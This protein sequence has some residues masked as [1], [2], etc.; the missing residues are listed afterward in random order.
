M[1]PLGKAPL[2]NELKEASD[3]SMRLW[4]DGKVEKMAVEVWGLFDKVASDLD[5]SLR[6]IHLLS[7]K[8]GD[9]DLL[10]RV[11]EAVKPTFPSEAEQ[12]I[13]SC[14]RNK[15]FVPLWGLADIG[16]DFSVCQLGLFEGVLLEGGYPLAQK[17]FEGGAC[18]S[19]ANERVIL[20]KYCGFFFNNISNYSEEKALAFIDLAL[21]RGFDP[22]WLDERFL[23][24]VFRQC[25]NPNVWSRL[26][27]MRD[28]NFEEGVEFLSIFCKGSR[29]TDK[30]LTCLEQFLS[31]MPEG[32]NLWEGEEGFLPCYFASRGMVRNR[33]EDWLVDYYPD[34]KRK[35]GVL[36]SLGRYEEAMPLIAK[37]GDSWDTCFFELI[38]DPNRGLSI[39]H[40]LKKS[41]QEYRVCLREWAIY[42]PEKF[43]Q[44]NDEVKWLFVS[45]LP[46]ESLRELVVKEE[47]D[48]VLLQNWKHKDF[49]TIIELS[50]AFKNH[51]WSFRCEKKLRGLN[52]QAVAQGVMNGY[53]DFFV[54]AIGSL[55][56]DQLRVAL[57]GLD[58]EYT[59]DLLCNKLPLNLALEVVKLT[60]EDIKKP[61]VEGL[62]KRNFGVDNAALEHEVFGK[63]ASIPGMRMRLDRKGARKFEECSQDFE[64]QYQKVIEAEGGLQKLETFFKEEGERA[65]GG[66]RDLLD[67][68]LYEVGCSLKKCR[69]WERMRV[70]VDRMEKNFTRLKGEVSKRIGML[71]S[72]VREQGDEPFSSPEREMSIMGKRAFEEEN[73]FAKRMK[74]DSV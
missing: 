13:Q 40:T 48:Q 63:M 8:G 1:E 38:K 55:G 36:L 54:R 62:R 2:F 21:E 9:E 10:E 68:S 4:S 12:I 15:D 22:A 61:F 50:D 67:V 52:F 11:K 7:V 27:S 51:L 57:A 32:L 72:V 43:Q 37:L 70:K 44:L 35:V 64:E 17:V 14:F 46:A 42:C 69:R 3:L 33:V 20:E 23:V 25:D 39:L 53:H 49:D 28:V 34:D 19:K 74:L 18:F 31:R 30:Y 56:K 41:P 26:L 71:A 59:L 66:L 73:S 24:K 5:L 45:V 16:F 29:N 60:R 58:D 47:M 6:V 65:E